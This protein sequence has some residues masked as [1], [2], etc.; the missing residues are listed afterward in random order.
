MATVLGR[1][2][3]PLA[4][5]LNKTLPNHFPARVEVIRLA[6]PVNGP[7]LIEEGRVELTIVQTD[8]AYTAYTKGLPNAPRPFRK[9]RGVAVLYPS[10]IHLI[11]SERSGIRSLRDLKG[12]RLAIGSGA[13]QESVARAIL[14][15]AG[16][17]LSDVDAKRLTDD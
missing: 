13:A 6:G 17:T 12:K 9:L 7:Q 14:E 4:D 16:L 5:A 1:V 11:A 15:G 8:S 3:N 10:P 2:I